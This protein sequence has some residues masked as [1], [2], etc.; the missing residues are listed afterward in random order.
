MISALLQGCVCAVGSYILI[1]HLGLYGAVLSE[2]VGLFLGASYVLWRFFILCP[3]S[4][5]E[6]MGQSPS[7]TFAIPVVFAG[8]IFV[9]GQLTTINSLVALGALACLSLAL[10]IGISFAREGMGS[11]AMEVL[12]EFLPVKSELKTP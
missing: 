11:I 10:Y 1:P 8:C 7:H 6:M 9:V 4:N 12:R 2:L 5:R 3:M